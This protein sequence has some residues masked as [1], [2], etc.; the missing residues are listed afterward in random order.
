MYLSIYL[1]IYSAPIFHFINNNKQK[2]II[3]TIC[4]SVNHTRFLK[5]DYLP[6]WARQDNKVIKGDHVK[7]IY[8]SNLFKNFKK[9]K[10]E[11]RWVCN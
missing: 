8:I 7:N 11:V 3:K 6:D 5:K 4:D 10:E 1:P 2:E 9:M